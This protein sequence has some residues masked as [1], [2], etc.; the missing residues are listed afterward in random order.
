MNR[1]WLAMV[2][3]FYNPGT[4]EVE[5]GRPAALFPTAITTKYLSDS[6]NVQQVDVQLESQNEGRENM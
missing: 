4:W 6:D 5:E 3:H 1:S 2:V